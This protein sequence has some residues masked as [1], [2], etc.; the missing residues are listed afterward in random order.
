LKS[1]QDNFLQIQERLKELN[2]EIISILPEVIA[3]ADLIEYIKKE[4]FFKNY[5]K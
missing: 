1:K 3:S 5:K 2:Q 4:E